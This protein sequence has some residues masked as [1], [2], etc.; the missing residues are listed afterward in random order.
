MLGSLIYMVALGKTGLQEVAKQNFQKAHYLKKAI[1]KLQGYKIV[2]TKPTY[3]E[4]LVECPNLERLI[5]L[6][7]Q[8]GLLPP[9]SVEKY[10]PKMKN[11]ALICVT[12]MNTKESLDQFIGVAKEAL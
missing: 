8:K 11:F 1:S 6:C 7:K 12:E 4:F 2:N 5:T 3:N 10:F 9:F